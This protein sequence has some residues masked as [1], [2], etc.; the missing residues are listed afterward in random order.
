[1]FKKYLEIEIKR[2]DWKGGR[3]IES[4]WNVLIN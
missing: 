2:D 4:W 3:E 1:M